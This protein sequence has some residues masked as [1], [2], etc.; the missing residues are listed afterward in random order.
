M[1]LF[2]TDFVALHG[3]KAVVAYRFSI[4]EKGDDEKRVRL[5]YLVGSAAD[6][7]AYADRLAQDD[8]VLSAAAEYQYSI[9]FDHL[10]RVV[11]IKSEDTP[12]EE[13]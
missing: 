6:M 1:K 2:P 4:R 10:F 7:Q 8:Q 12:S 13:V 3:E 11:A 5:C 9:D